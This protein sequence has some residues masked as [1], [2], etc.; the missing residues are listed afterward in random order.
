MATLGLGVGGSASIGIGG[1]ASLG[2][3]AGL[4]VKA[5]ASL[6][7]NARAG[8]GLGLNAAFS[9]TT[10]LLGVRTDPYA[11]FNFLVEIEGLVIGGFTE[12]SGLSMETTVQE[13]QAGGPNDYVHKLP[14]PTRYPQNLTLKRGLTDLDMLGSWYQDVTTGLVERKNGTV[15]LLD[16]QGNPAL[17]WDFKE[18]YPVKWTG[19][20]L[21]GESNTVASE[22]LELVHRGLAKSAVSGLLAGVAAGISGAI[23]ASLN[24]SLGASVGL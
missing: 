8:L 5:G 7:L 19:P 12:V 16:L 21:R 23:G 1:S 10:N 18:A 14:G 3:S 17:G 13:Y 15:Y 20:D 24:V 11:G 9:L 2:V 6:S 4:S 22:S